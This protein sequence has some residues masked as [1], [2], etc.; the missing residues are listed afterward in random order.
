MKPVSYWRKSY[1]VT[2][3]RVTEENMKEL[4]ESINAGFVQ[5]SEGEDGYIVLGGDFFAHKGDWIVLDGDSQERWTHEEFMKEFRTLSE[6]MTVSALQSSL[7]KI[8]MDAMHAA[9]FGNEN[10]DSPE[11]IAMDAVKRI[12]EL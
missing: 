10:S 1:H 11:T 4:A 8:V 6:V 12:I 9:R 2:A 7:H 3:V 5:H